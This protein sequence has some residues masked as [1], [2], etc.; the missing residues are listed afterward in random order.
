MD[1]SSYARE[2]QN[3]I[4]A[5]RYA[6]LIVSLGSQ[7]NRAQDRFDKSDFIEQ[8]VAE[9]SDG[10]LRWVDEQGRDFRDAEYGFDIE[11]KYE[12]DLMFTA[13]RKNPSSSIKP[14]IK[15]SLGQNKGTDIPDMAEF[16]L[17]GQQDALALVSADT[18]KEYLVSV[19]DGIEAH[20][21]FDALSF[22]FRPEDVGDVEPVEIN[23]KTRKMEMQREILKSI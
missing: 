5:E 2:L 22:V 14:K 3:V 21:D 17:L 4:D 6:R 12:S 9:F 8:G 19:P 13:A 23:Y 1:A 15:N 10:R 20:L 11:F 7:L 18:L 16:Y